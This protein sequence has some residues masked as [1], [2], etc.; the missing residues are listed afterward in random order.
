MRKSNKK[1]SQSLIF[2]KA[3]FKSVATF[4]MNGSSSPSQRVLISVL[5]IT[6]SIINGA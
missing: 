1:A 6:H 2:V 4:S 3:A 5:L